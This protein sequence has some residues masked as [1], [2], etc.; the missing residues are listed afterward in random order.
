MSNK[1]L[2]EFRKERNLS[3]SEIAEIIGVSKSQY[4]KIEYGQRTPSFRFLYKFK[5]AFPEANV[6]SLFLEINHTACV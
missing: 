2:S 4:D 6:D 1:K 5:Y 3:T